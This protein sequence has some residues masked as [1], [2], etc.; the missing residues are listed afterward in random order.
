MN[1]F[2]TTIKRFKERAEV[3][4]FGHLDAKKI[5]KSLSPDSSK[6]ER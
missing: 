3:L 4:R 5:E 6:I 1:L 2:E